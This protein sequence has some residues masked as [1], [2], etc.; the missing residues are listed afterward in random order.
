[1]WGWV[2]EDGNGRGVWIRVDCVWDLCG[3]KEVD[4]GGSGEGASVAE[5]GDGGQERFQLGKFFWLQFYW[6]VAGR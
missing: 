6:L 5:A 2:G 3:V 4:G 1:M